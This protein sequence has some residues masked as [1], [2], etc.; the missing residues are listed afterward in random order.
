LRIA[1]PAKRCIISDGCAESLTFLRFYRMAIF[2][3]ITYHC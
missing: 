2:K 1:Q 3:K